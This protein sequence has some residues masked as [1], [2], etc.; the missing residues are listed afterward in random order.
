M[1]HFDTYFP[2]IFLQILPIRLESGDHA[3]PLC[4]KVMKKYYHMNVHIRSHTGEKPFKCLYCE[5]RTST[6]SNL[7]THMNYKHCHLTSTN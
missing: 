3:C 4:S 7:K 6:K 2:T 5:Y 1:V